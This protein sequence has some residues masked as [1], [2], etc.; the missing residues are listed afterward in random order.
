MGEH[1]ATC[2]VRAGLECLGDGN[3]GACEFAARSDEYRA[4]LV[5]RAMLLA[6]WPKVQACPHRGAVL[7]VS[8]Q[9]DCGCVGTELTECRAGRGK[10]K[11]PDAVAIDECAACVLRE[12]AE[13]PAPA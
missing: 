2:P 11:H 3:P 4:M 8:R 7:P 5:R 10:P 9:V 12:Q 13:L 1:C 6:A